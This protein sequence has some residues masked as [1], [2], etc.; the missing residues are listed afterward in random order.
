MEDNPAESFK[1]CGTLIGTVT[2]YYQNRPKEAQK[3]RFDSYSSYDAFHF[4]ML[5]SNEQKYTQAI[6]EAVAKIYAKSGLGPSEEEREAFHHLCQEINNTILSSQRVGLYLDRVDT[7][8]I[9]EWE[10]KERRLQTSEKQTEA[11]AA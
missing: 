4:H 6:D 11:L 5:S 1:A 3:T 8:E 7:D 10:L 2:L 9:L